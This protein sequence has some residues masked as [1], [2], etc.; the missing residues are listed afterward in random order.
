MMRNGSSRQSLYDLVEDMRKDFDKYTS[1]SLSLS[2][3]QINSLNKIGSSTGNNPYNV[4]FTSS[5]TVSK[6]MT[7]STVS[8]NTS[9]ATSATNAPQNDLAGTKYAQIA[10]HYAVGTPWVP[11]DQVA[12]LHRGEMVVPA[13]VN[14][15]GHPEVAAYTDNSDVV[16]AIRWL[17]TVI[18]TKIDEVERKMDNLPT[19]S[20][21]TYPYK[22]PSMTD[23]A[24]SF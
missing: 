13:D 8:A 2:T 4:S 20:A 7:P 23:I 19:S 14:P 16:D 6:L 3:Q 21:P 5:A 17:G 15:L 9:N 1:K 18:G 10:G 12:V 11:E 22:T 24:F